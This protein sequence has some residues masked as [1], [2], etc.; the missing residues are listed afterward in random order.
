M[1]LD[2]DLTQRYIFYTLLLF[3]FNKV[4]NHDGMEMF[5]KL[6]YLFRF[7]TPSHT[8]QNLINKCW[9]DNMD[10]T[11]SFLHAITLRELVARKVIRLICSQNQ[12]LLL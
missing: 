4:M 7:H 2:V 6:V 8:F 3:L 9:C 10:D 12:T 11:F 1:I 5:S